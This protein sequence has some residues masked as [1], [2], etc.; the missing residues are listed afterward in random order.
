[1]IAARSTWGGP[2]GA[3]GTALASPMTAVTVHHTHSPTLPASATVTQERS[4]VL[5]VH[6]HHAS[7]WAGVG[8]HF[9]ICQSGRIYEGRGWGRVGAHAGAG[10]GNRT[11]GVVFVINGET[12]EPSADALHALTWLRDEGVKLG[13]L[14]RGHA[15][16]LHSDWMATTCPGKRVA[17]ALQSGPSTHRIDGHVWRVGDRGPLTA[18]L[19][20]LL[21]AGGYMTQLE[22]D[23]GPGIHGQR[24][25]RALRTML[26]A[27][28]A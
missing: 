6:R 19:Q 4:A 25:E 21:V 17:T 28:L 20:Q 23:T 12:T 7:K 18:L 14:T 24:T 5:A 1:M 13:H 3:I 2:S 16:K 27:H 9:L 22:A 10:G 8:Y 15:L 26:A 11:L